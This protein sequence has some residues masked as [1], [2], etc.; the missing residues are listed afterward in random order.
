MFMVLERLLGPAS[1]LLL[2]LSVLYQVTKATILMLGTTFGEVEMCS[3]IR[4]GCPASGSLFVLLL[5]PWHKMLI[6]RIPRS[7]PYCFADDVA[8]ILGEFFKDFMLLHSLLDLLSSAAALLLN[9][10]KCVIVPLCDLDEDTGSR[11]G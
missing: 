4:Q 1:P 7:W 6:H 11:H 2:A 5:D 8:I 10:S 9:M 3:G